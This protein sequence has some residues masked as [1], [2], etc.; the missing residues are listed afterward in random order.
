MKKGSAILFSLLFL[1]LA[2]CDPEKDK[3]P[4]KKTQDITGPVVIFFN[5]SSSIEDSLLKLNPEQFYRDRD[6][7]TAGFFQLRTELDSLGIKYITTNSDF[8][9]VKG[10]AIKSE[11]SIKEFKKPWGV[12]FI[13][14]NGLTTLLTNDRNSKRSALMLMGG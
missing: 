5:P 12:I 2:S 13:D 7:I 9:S 3:K 14:R 8:L 10:C 4:E 11:I 1:F 6:S